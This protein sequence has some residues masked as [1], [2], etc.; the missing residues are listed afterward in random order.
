MPSSLAAGSRGAYPA[1]AMEPSPLP[2]DLETLARAFRHNGERAAAVCQGLGEDQGMLA[3]AAGAWSVAQCLDHLTIVDRA[4]LRHLEVAA[5]APRARRRPADTSD[6]TRPGPLGRWIVRQL[7]PPPRFGTRLPAR[8]FLR[9]REHA[10]LAEALS[11]LLGTHRLYLDFL[12]ASR[13]LDLRGIHL[14]SPVF[15][16]LRLSAA[17]ALAVVLAHERRH[18]QQAERTRER[19]VGPPA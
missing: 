3:P 9:P 17:S 19:V 1:G 7:E 8:R 4:Y 5:A 14:A 12:A 18:L 13:D 11:D 10:R 15:R 2:P 16:L 6:V